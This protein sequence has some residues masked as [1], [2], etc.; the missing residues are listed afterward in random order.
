MSINPERERTLNA[1]NNEGWK[2]WG[3]YL[4]ERQW[5]TVREDYSK[6]GSAWD[7]IPHEKARSNAYR[8]G[9]EGIGGISDNKQ[10]M[11]F[12]PS[13]WNGKDAILKE[14]LF[15]LT[16][17]EGNHGE[18]VKELYYYVDS[19]PTHSYM[20]MLYKYP[21][22]AFP[23]AELVQENKKR[24]KK[25]PEYEIIDTGIF[26]NDE[27]F[28]IF[29]EYAK[30]SKTDTLIRIT[31]HNRGEKS[32]NFHIIPTIWFRNTWEPKLTIKPF[33][34]EKDGMLKAKHPII[35]EYNLYSAREGEILICDNETNSK[36]VY[37]NES[38]NHYFKDGINDYVIDGKKEAVKDL[39]EQGTKAGFYFEDEI[40]GKSSQTYEL[41]FTKDFYENPFEDFNE[42]FEQRI[43]DTTIFYDELQKAVKNP[44]LKRIQR[45][46]YAGM[47]WSKQFYYY[48]V[49][50]W[51][52]GDKGDFKPYRDN[53]RNYEWDNMYAQNI[54]SMPDKWEYP[55]FAAWDLAFHTVTLAYL[56]CEFAK[57]QLL[58][59]LREY[60]MHPNGQIP[61]YEWHF[62]DVNPPVHAWAAWK[63]FEID[64]KLNKKSDHKFLENIF[65]KLT[66]NFTWWINQKDAT[67]NNIF[68]GGFLGLDNIGVFDRSYLPEGVSNLEQADATSWM[69]MY[70]LNMLRISLELATQNEIYQE[71]ASKFFRH[72]L[73]IGGAMANMGGGNITAEESDQ[74]IGLWDKEDNFYYDLVHLKDGSSKQLKVRSLVGIIPLFAVEVIDDEL[75]NS[76]KAFKRRV[77]S[78]LSDRP[79]LAKWVSHI[80]ESS[81]NGHLLSIVRGYRL[82]HILDRLLDEDEFL[83]DFG[84]RSMSKY[85]KDNPYHFDVD[86]TTLSISYES[87]ESQSGMFGGNSN[88]RGPIWF[89]LNYMLLLSLDKYASYYGDDFT[90]EFPKGSG[91][92]LTLK[93]VSKEIRKRL[94]KLFIPDKDG[95]KP[96]YSTYDKLQS[97]G[98]FDYHMFYEYFD[99]E[100]G[101][102][103]GA[104]HQTGWTGLIANIIQELS[105]D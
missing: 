18:D 37:G 100:T 92:F 6:D 49:H 35:G 78:Y 67:G 91:I 65:Q 11:C 60:Y 22:S 2:R 105:E 39:S 24:T 68:E 76:M 38:A 32:A 27:Y 69:A 104:S 30:Q 41:R 20:K 42:I 47:L 54:L 102:G 94:L 74:G 10:N 96:Y 103:L 46:A 72:F 66:S 55:W 62:G 51:V 70:S 95:K 34:E 57:R 16:G 43:S 7:Y 1:K 98:E 36:K 31:V 19:T 29:I 5:G 90:Y 79:D 50:K 61:A 4:S 88:W 87:G 93:E 89:P 14:R 9:E 25:D 13:F 33:I 85:H 45:Q 3:P 63:V 15:G 17:V 21:H 97:G 26:D 44:E 82:K 84:I 48:D 101:K 81:G 77:N 99:P 59:L 83:S 73:S 53:Q 86:G 52:N 28:D 58:L 64:K 40:E 80:G 71:S 75:F 12:S 56:D 23:Y 8:W